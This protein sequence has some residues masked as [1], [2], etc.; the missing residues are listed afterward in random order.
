M[1]PYVK[2]FSAPPQK[3]GFVAS[4]RNGKAIFFTLVALLAALCM[5]VAA[6]ENTTTESPEPPPSEEASPQP[7]Q[8]PPADTKAMEPAT[9]RRRWISG[10]IEASV[11]A[12]SSESEDSIDLDQMLQLNIDPLSNEKL[13]LRS[14]FWLREDLESIDE[15]SPL[16]DIDDSF[17]GDVHGNVVNLHLDIDDLWGESILRIGR[18]RINEGTAY[19]RLDG[20]FFK[21]ELT[22]WQ[23]YVYAGWQAS[24]YDHPFDDPALGGGAQFQLS[25]ATRLAVDA[26]WIDE[27]RLHH[28][29]AYRWRIANWFYRD[30]PREVERDIHD[31]SIALSIWQ[32]V[33]E[34]IRFMGRFEWLDAESHRLTL[35]TTGFIPALDTSFEVRYRQLFETIEDR[36]SDLTSYYRVLGPQ[37]QYKELRIVLHRPLTQRLSL[38]IEAEFRDADSEEPRDRTSAWNQAYFY[39]DK[40]N[41]DLQHYSA[42]LTAEKLP[43]NLE[44]SLYGE[45][46]D[47]DNFDDSWQFGG[48]ITKRWDA[49][50]LTLGAEYVSYDDYTTRY[51]FWPSFRN[52]LRSAFLALNNSSLSTF[53]YDNNFTVNL[54][55]VVRVDAG[56][57]IVS[58]F[59]EARWKIDSN[60]DI[61]ASVSI[62]EDDS[63]DSPYWRVRAGYTRKF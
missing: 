62:E 61:H 58:V 22:R 42:T 60:Q 7:E 5:P 39:V 4:R 49:W 31:S 63:E 45:Y 21:K 16:R 19:N 35:Q 9:P 44:A 6:Q 2:S 34:N 38:S 37:R 14:L 18:Q 47:I 29:D 51:N 48:D 27:D 17:S 59:A 25:P 15:Q 12:I 54:R 13:H 10:Q 52:E 46:W 1:S 20:I 53:Y 57:D 23:W 33:T 41:Q 36:A 30:Y 28:P 55:D 40:S 11:D 50:S 56:N 24:L 8:A 43:W 32:K 3:A 26:Y